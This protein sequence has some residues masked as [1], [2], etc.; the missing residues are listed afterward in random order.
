MRFGEQVAMRT[1]NSY[2][3]MTIATFLSVAFASGSISRAPGDEP[4][5]LAAMKLELVAELESASKKSSSLAT[6]RRGRKKTRHGLPAQIAAAREA[7]KADAAKIQEKLDAGKSSL[8]VALG[9]AANGRIYNIV[10]PLDK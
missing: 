2:N 7:W 5:S 8:A 3:W 10:P 9:Q 4:A 6:S 1:I